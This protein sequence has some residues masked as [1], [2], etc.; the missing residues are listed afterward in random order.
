[1]AQIVL[2]FRKQVFEEYRTWERIDQE[3]KG[4]TEILELSFGSKS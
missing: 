3:W 2:P 1:M 4:I